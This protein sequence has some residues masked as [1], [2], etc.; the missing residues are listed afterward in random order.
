MTE[1]YTKW[2]ECVTLEV[3]TVNSP[4]S[5]NR[6]F[7]LLGFLVH[8]ANTKMLLA[9]FAVLGEESVAS[10]STAIK[11]FLKLHKKPPETIVTPYNR[12][13]YKSM[14]ILIE[15]RSFTGSHIYSL[16]GFISHLQD[17][18]SGSS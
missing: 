7:K 5:P 6:N 14:K 11:I 17:K 16:P 13:M 15:E 1:N 4:F 8:E 18:L 3:L 10:V 9:G 12:C 2:G